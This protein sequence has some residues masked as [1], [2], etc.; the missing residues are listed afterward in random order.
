VG[1]LHFKGKLSWGGKEE[2]GR[3][4]RTERGH[5][6]VFLADTCQIIQKVRHII[7]TSLVKSRSND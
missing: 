3:R 2:E 7:S 6:Q 4:W 1:V 5:F